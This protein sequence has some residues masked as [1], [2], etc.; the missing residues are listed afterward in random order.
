MAASRTART[1]Q[2]EAERE[3]AAARGE[4]YA[5]VI[6][7]GPRW[8]A[9]APLPHLIGNG[10][11]TFA[12]CLADQ[13]DPDWDGNYLTIASVDDDHPSLFVMIELW[14]CQEIRLGGPNDELAGHP[15]Y[16]WVAT[17]PTRS[18]ARPGSRTPSG[19]TPSTRTTPTPRSG[20]SITTSCCST[21]RCSKPTPTDRGG[22]DPGNAAGHPDR[23]DQHPHRPALPPRITSSQASS[24]AGATGSPVTVH[25]QWQHSGTDR[26]V[27]HVYGPRPC[28]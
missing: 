10:S 3:L 21:T 15:L 17:R 12:V 7:I 4:P 24:P 16:G 19:S 20:N 22:A 1:D 8:D 14:G 28:W 9:G 5:R 18:P 11:R 23:P 2:L 27:F 13:P 26:W 6:D 25:D